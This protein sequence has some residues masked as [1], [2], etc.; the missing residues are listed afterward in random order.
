MRATLSRLPAGLGQKG[1]NRTLILGLLLLISK[2]GALAQMAE[3]EFPA[4]PGYQ[5]VKH[6]LQAAAREFNVE[7]EL[8]HAVIAKESRFD[9]AAV[10]PGGAVGLMQIMPATA[11]NFGVKADSATSIRK[12]LS[13]PV[14]N[15]STGSRYLRYLMNLFPGRLEL[16]L[17]AYNAGEGTVKRAGNQI[18]NIKITQNY[19]KTVMQT[20]AQL[21]SRLS[22]AARADTPILA[23]TEIIEAPNDRVNLTPSSP[24]VHVVLPDTQ[25]QE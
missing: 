5:M 13:D 8:L 7:Y 18:P 24:A 14:T 9:P 6:H 19:V 16:A 2:Q 10:S 23:A 21:K 12:K 25:L 22:P 20:Y 15:L 3:P 1:L 4:Y 11:A 17:A